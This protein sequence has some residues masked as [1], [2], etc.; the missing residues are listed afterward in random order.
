MVDG[1]GLRWWMAVGWDGGWRWVG[2]VDGGGLRWWMAEV[3]GL[4][5]M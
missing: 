4:G 3:S 5:Y 2:M 1:G